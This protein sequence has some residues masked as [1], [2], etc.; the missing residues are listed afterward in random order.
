MKQTYRIKNYTIHTTS[1][2]I[3]ITGHIDDNPYI[4]DIMNGD[5][6]LTDDT[7]V[8]YEVLKCERSK[9]AF[10]DLSGEHAMFKVKEI[11]L[12]KTIKF[13]PNHQPYPNCYAD[14]MWGIFICE[15]NME[16]KAINIVKLYDSPYF[17]VIPEMNGD[18]P[19]GENVSP[20]YTLFEGLLIKK[21]NT[22]QEVTKEIYKI[23]NIE[24][25]ET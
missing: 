16:E 7:K 20:W 5:H 22:Y 9:K 23:L 10:G 11:N 15:D 25:N 24:S 18:N 2:G 3:L 6:L 21:Y 19:T 14:L 17:E 1:D 12:V 13:V 4:F 8:L